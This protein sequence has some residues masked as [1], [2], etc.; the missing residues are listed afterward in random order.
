MKIL[1]ISDE[2]DPL[3]YSEHITTR[4]GDVDLILS[5][6]D[7]PLKYYEFI[8]SMLNKPLYFVFGNHNQEHLHQYL[9]NN[10]PTYHEFHRHTGG[11][12]PFGGEFVDGKVR[13]DKRNKL[14]IAGL[15]GSMR[16]NNGEHQFTDAQMFRRMVKMMPRLIYNRIVRGRYVDIL[17]THAPP[18]G[19]GDGIDL[20]HKGFSSFLLFMKWF[21][22]AYLLH[23]HIHLVDFNANRIHPF[24][25]TKVINIFRNHLL[26]D[27][28]LGGETDV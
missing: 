8:I 11:I 21:K 2:A 9:S 15:G 19:L 13:Y 12:P 23:G 27:D 20:P 6:G 7:L 24:K 18:L 10:R 3:I 26:E 28:Q 17:L 22:P 25:Q 4:Y 1:C 5:A 14:I 16:Y